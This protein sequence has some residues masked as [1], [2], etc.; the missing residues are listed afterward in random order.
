MG[1]NV[2][3]VIGNSRAS[4]AELRMFNTAREHARQP[5][6]NVSIA[7]RKSLYDILKDK[8]SEEAFQSFD[9][10]FEL[11]DQF[12]GRP[13]RFVYLLN[14]IVFNLRVSN[15][16]WSLVWFCIADL[17]YYPFLI[18]SSPIIY[19][20][21]SPDIARSKKTKRY[22]T[23]LPR[24]A[25]VCISENVYD[26]LRA[27]CQSIKTVVFRSCAY[28]SAITNVKS[29]AEMSKRRN[30]VIFAHRLVERKNPL[31]AV[32]AF[33]SLERENPDWIFTI[34]GRGP[35]QSKVEEKI[36]AAGA[37]RVTF[38]GY[39]SNLPAALLTSK[40]FV[41]L[42][43][44]DNYPSQSVIQALG[45]GN[46]MVILASGKGSGRFIDGNGVLVSKDA[47]SVADG[48]SS[49]LSGD[50]AVMAERSL[51]IVRNRFSNKSYLAEHLRLINT[52]SQ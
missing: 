45:A 52:F 16:R 50:F 12:L 14:L 40:V 5:E 2:L 43:E 1:K 49:I 17:F 15:T 27:K 35:L 11:D 32:D 47:K 48:I 3:Y 26:I 8:Y 25:F 23:W 51:K 18:F 31:L 28:N 21:T 37:S 4:G 9:K 13:S 19:E 33:L 41:S 6:S 44:P 30:E 36:A 22:A 34:Y 38:R 10:C 42:I 20:V 7:L 39:C 46:A 24:C 29:L